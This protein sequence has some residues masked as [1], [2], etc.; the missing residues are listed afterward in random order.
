MVIDPFLSFGK[1]VL[2]GTG[3]PTGIIF[4]RFDVGESIAE[5]ADDYA[6]SPEQLEEAIRYELPF[7]QAA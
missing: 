7:R 1:P 6:L 2:A 5:L 4:H 3:I